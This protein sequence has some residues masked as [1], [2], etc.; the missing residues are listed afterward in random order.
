MLDYKGLPSDCRPTLYLHLRSILQ[1]YNT[2]DPYSFRELEL[3]KNAEEWIYSQATD[4]GWTGLD[5]WNGYTLHITLDNLPHP[6]SRLMKRIRKRKIPPDTIMD[7]HPHVKS[8]FKPYSIWRR[9]KHPLSN[10]N[11]YIPEKSSSLSKN[12]STSDGMY[13]RS[14]SHLLKGYD[15]PNPSINIPIQNSTTN[16]NSL[17]GYHG[18]AKPI[19]K[20]FSTSLSDEL[21]RRSLDDLGNGSGGSNASGVVDSDDTSTT[22]ESPEFPNNITSPTPAM[23]SQYNT[24][25][26][27]MGVPT[28]RTPS[29]TYSNNLKNFSISSQHDVINSISMDLS[30]LIHTTFYRRTY[31]V[32]GEIHKTLH[33]GL[34]SLLLASLVLIVCLA[35][36]RLVDILTPSSSSSSSSS[37]ESPFSTS[38]TSSSFDETNASSS[39][40]ASKL[41]FNPSNWASIGSEA[42]ELMGWVALW[43]PLEAMMYSWSPLIEKR[44]IMKRCQVCNIIIELQ[45]E[46]E[47]DDAE[48]NDNDDGVDDDQYYYKRKGSS[49]EDEN[50]NWRKRGMSSFRRK[51]SKSFY[52]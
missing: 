41:F 9:N 11:Q 5:N 23:Y 19:Q 17:H 49:W 24:Y 4:Q 39:S 52:Q 22:L 28:S 3:D 14:S 27:E 30:N 48:D 33:A 6:T 43:R 7:H 26:A 50:V 47:D 12:S 51:E 20:K 45:P 8:F 15:S 31:Q 42:L 2:S 38:S 25:Q 18:L 37:S 34:I 13:H 44:K 1:L 16:L 10:S 46:D 35:L 21:G 32:K 40:P 36:S 29:P